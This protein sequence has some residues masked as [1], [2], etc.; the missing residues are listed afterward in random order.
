[1]RRLTILLLALSLGCATAP[2]R[3]AVAPSTG[4]H[5]ASVVVVFDPSVAAEKVAVFEENG[6]DTSLQSRLTS[7][8][9]RAGRLDAGSPNTLEFRVTDF[10]LRS[11]A[12]VIWLGSMAGGDH[13]QGT[14][15][16]HT[17]DGD[18]DSFATGVSSIMGG[19]FVPPDSEVRLNRLIRV[20]VERIV[21]QQVA[22]D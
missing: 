16:I 14:V 3:A 20:L 19:G 8:L 12:A 15:V 7:A 13:I 18:R 9:T 5:V 11:T 1:M 4:A 17:P 21:K 2:H 10:R 6:G 22:M